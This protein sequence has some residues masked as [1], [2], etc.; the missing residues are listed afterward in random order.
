[1]IEIVQELEKRQV[2][3]QCIDAI[4]ANSYGAEQ[5]K[6]FPRGQVQQEIIAKLGL[7]RN[8]LLC[9]II[10]DRMKIAG[11]DAIANSGT[12]YYRHRDYRYTRP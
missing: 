7:V 4:I 12:L 2:L 3:V 6:R 5:R 9:N 10:T 1:M 8:N 11:F